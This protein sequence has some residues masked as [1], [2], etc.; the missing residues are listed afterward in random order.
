MAAQTV[1]ELQTLEPAT[2]SVGTQFRNHSGTSAEI[3]LSVAGT[4]ACAASEEEHYVAA[5]AVATPVVSRSRTALVIL[6]VCGQSFFSSYCNGIIVIALPAIQA[7]LGLDESLLVW[8]SSSYFLAAGSCLLLAG[9]VAD[10]S[11]NKRVNLTGSFL[12]AIFTSACGL[13]RTGGQIIA[14]RALQGLAYAVVTPSSVSIVS[15]SL[16]EGKPRNIG[17]ACMGFSQPIGFCFGL[18]LGGVFTDTLGWRPAFYL[19]AAATGALFLASIWALPRDPRLEPGLPVWKKLARDIDC[20]GIVVSSTGLASISYV[21]ASLSADIHNIRSV[22]SIVL[23]AISALSVPS[24]IGWMH[25]R[26]KKNRTSLIP[27]SLWRSHVF[28][29]C[30]IMVLLTNGLTNCME[31][32]SSLFFQQVQG[33][34]AIQASLQ[35]VPSLVA[36]ALIS[37]ATGIFVHRMPVIWMLSIGSVMSTVAPLLMGLVRIDQLYWGNAFFAQIL[38]PISCDLL[39]TIGL[40]IISNVFPPHMQA[41]SGAV[42]NTCAQLGSAIGLSVTQVIAASV[43][44]ALPNKSSPDSLMRGYRTAF[45]TMFGWMAFACLVCITGMRRVGVIG[46]KRD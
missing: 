4:N 11:G 33:S 3:Q 45:W 30:C 13:A 19:A 6:Q 35:V 17:F 21:L 42:F 7:E 16:D 23:L 14:F 31:L 25:Y 37:I 27:N 15:K 5:A 18:I 12:S 22:A 2:S 9:S 29:S 43:T 41:L 34:S 36:G 24:F 8:P 40:L 20:I 32:Y 38:T 44:N 39:F 26:K 28:T 10:V 1:T 46:L